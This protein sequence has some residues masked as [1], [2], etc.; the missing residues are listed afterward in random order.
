MS[1]CKL[2]E[3]T[4]FAFS[5]VG[6][7]PPPDMS[8]LDRLEFRFGRYAIPGLIRYVVA[9]N[10]LVY[11]LVKFNPD[12]LYV[13]MLWPRGIL[14][15]QVWRLV[16]Y[17]FIPQFGAGILPEWFNT[18]M[19]LLVMWWIGNGVE[20]ALGPFKLNV[21][22]LTGMLGITIAAFFFGQGFSALILNASL[23]FA[24]AQFYPDEVI[25]IMYILPAKVKW[26]AWIAAAWLLFQAFS[27]GLEY[28]ISLV[29]ALANYLVF[30]GPEMYRNARTRQQASDRRRKFEAA[31]APDTATMHE[32][33]VCHR[34][35]ASNPEL[36][37]R[38]ARDGQEYCVE[39]L[40][41]PAPAA[42]N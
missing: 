33:T 38:V 4:V 36:D 8:F 25:F 1:D 16:T 14:H 24:F 6:V 26:L 13:L 9:L 3:P 31:Q 19:Y 35:E 39:H 17:I 20:Q 40:P 30:F 21:Y 41:K 2:G 29:V 34:T 10:A 28:I 42:G 27:N 5:M 7:N 37:F 32:C 22:Y 15:G 12:F 18:A 23:L 11:I